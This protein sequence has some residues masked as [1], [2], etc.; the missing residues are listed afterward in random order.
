MG[1]KYMVFRVAYELKK[2]SSYLKVK[3]PTVL[4][5][6]KFSSFEKWKINAQSFFQWEVSSPVKLTGIEMEL[7][8][9]NVERFREGEMQYFS[10]KWYKMGIDEWHYNPFSKH[11]YSKT[12]HWAQIPE[13]T[14]EAGD[15]KYVWEKARFS[16]VYSFIRY[17]QYSNQDSSEFVLSSIESFIDHNPINQ[18]PNYICSQ[19]ISLRVLNWIYALYF[20]KDSVALTEERFNGILNSVNAQITHVYSNINF[21]RIAVRNNHAI[22]ETLT[23]YLIGM[24]F[25][26]LPDAKKWK[27]NGRKWFEEEIE[28]QIYDD[29]SYLQYSMNYHR[30]V[31]QLLTWAIVISENNE[32][33]LAT[34]VYEKA[35]KTIS[36]LE[37]C[38]DPVSGKLPHYGNNDGALFFPLN[39]AEYRD[40]RSQINALKTALNVPIANGEDKES[41]EELYWYGL[42]S[43]FIKDDTNQ[44]INESTDKLSNTNQ[45]KTGGYYTYKD[46]NT[47][48]FIRCGSHYNRPSQADNL[49]LDIWING[50]NVLRD[51]GTYL[52]NGSTQEVKYFN[53]TKAHNTIQLGEE[54][55]M[56]RGNR[57]IW[58][59]WSKAIDV[60][61]EETNEYWIFKGAI[62]AFNGL[63]VKRVVKRYKNQLIW[64]IED[65]IIDKSNEK[66]MHQ[67][68]HP[69]E[70]AGISISMSCKDITGNKVES[71]ETK[72][73]YA[74]NYGQSKPSPIFTFS[75]NS[76]YLFTRIEV[77]S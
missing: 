42:K 55:Q 5:E 63:V 36:F 57:F 16:W 12:K 43:N 22:T 65:K 9:R 50:V 73:W 48:T 33:K 4:K 62:L 45:S 52:Y 66:F 74:P 2:K 11:T 6:I 44:Q 34:I 54:D 19:E 26:F 67:H 56:V 59:N 70:T 72:G 20:Y 14:N 7:L 68:W 76:N 77:A 24:L 60:E 37:G 53:S 13:F 28:Y 17:D 64:E 46:D 18:G 61:I 75:T 32:E 25:P 15:I 21:S 3:F 58:F 27:E 23:L 40:Y 41:L 69:N 29:G 35:K 8:S 10:S 47:L 30:V 51:S 39:C 31:V 49:H 71:I 38:Q 1:L